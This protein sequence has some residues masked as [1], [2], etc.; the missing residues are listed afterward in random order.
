MTWFVLQEA[1]LLDQ[2]KAQTDLQPR[3]CLLAFYLNNNI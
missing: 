2:S 1:C 3:D